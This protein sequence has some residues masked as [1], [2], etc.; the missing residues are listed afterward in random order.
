MR[1]PGAHFIQTVLRYTSR[2][3]GATRN[4]MVM[5]AGSMVPVAS[6]NLPLVSLMCSVGKSRGQG[7][8]IE[9]ASPNPHASPRIE[10]H[11]LMEETDRCRAVEA[12]QLAVDLARSPPLRDMATFFWPPPSAIERASGLKEWIGRIC[13]S[14]YHPCGTAIPM[15]ADDTPAALAALDGRGRVR[16]VEGLSVADASAMP[17]IPSAHT[18]LTA[19]MMGERFGAWLRDG[20]M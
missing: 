14:S 17:T 5:Q 15:G 3:S 16:G 13:D 7:T 8:F 9:F 20:G 2:G 6:A 4:D 11:L 12:M 18:N 19:L 10:S 1:V